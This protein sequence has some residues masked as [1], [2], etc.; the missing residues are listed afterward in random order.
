MMCHV[1]AGREGG[2]SEGRRRRGWEGKVKEGKE[3]R[4]RKGW[5]GDEWM[6]NG[7]KFF[8]FLPFLPVLPEE[9]G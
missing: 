1:E 5:K 9:I 4:D 8:F 7:W 3:K 2:R 6:L